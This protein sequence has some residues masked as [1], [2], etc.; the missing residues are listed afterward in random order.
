MESWFESRLPSQPPTPLTEKAVPE[1]DLLGLLPVKMGKNDAEFSPLTYPCAE[2]FPFLTEPLFVKSYSLILH[3]L[4]QREFAVL[5]TP[6]SVQGY[7]PRREGV[8]PGAS[9]FKAHDRAFLF[10]VDRPGRETG[11]QKPVSIILKARPNRSLKP[12]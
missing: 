9:I 11:C 12:R 4:R 3:I 8:I 5:K 10:Q 1:H 2:V 6:V 7:D